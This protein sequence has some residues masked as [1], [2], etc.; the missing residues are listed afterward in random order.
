M[1]FDRKFDPETQDF[2]RDGKGAFVRTETAETSM[3]NQMVAKRGAWWGDDQLGTLEDGLRGLQGGDPARDAEQ[4]F[5]LG[6]SR[7]EQMGRIADVTVVAIEDAPG[8]LLVQ[9]DCRDTSTG[10]PVT[11]RVKSGG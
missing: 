11:A 2:V 7:L 1:P 10:L 3:F 8:R 4:A 6:L 9:T 5:K